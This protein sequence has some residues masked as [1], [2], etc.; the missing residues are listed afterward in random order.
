[1]ATSDLLSSAYFGNQASFVPTGFGDVYDDTFEATI[2]GRQ[3]TAYLLSVA[4]EGRAF[5]E[6]NDLIRQ[7]FGRDIVAEVRKEF[8]EAGAD[9]LIK[10]YQARTDKIIDEGRAQNLD[11]WAGIRKAEEIEAATIDAAQVAQIESERTAARAENNFARFGGAL[12]GGV[13]ASF[14]DP[15]NLATLPVGAGAGVGIL[16]AALLDGA[17]NATIETAEAPFNAQWQ[18]ELGFKYGLSEATADIATAGIGGAGLSALIRGGSKALG[19]LTGQSEKV[20]RDIALDPAHGSEVRGAASYMERVAQLDENIPTPRV[21]DEVSPFEIT[22]AHRANA[23]ETQDAFRNYREP[24]YN[25]NIPFDVT[26]LDV[27]RAAPPARSFEE[28]LPEKGKYTG[29]TQPNVQ[30]LRFME[31]VVAELEQA[32]K[33]S[34]LFTEQDGAGGA[35]QVTT[36]QLSTFPKWFRDMNAEG[37]NLSRDYVLKTFEKM[38]QGEALGKKEIR[39]AKALFEEARGL[40]EQNA[41]QI[42]N[43]RADRADRLARQETEAVDALAAR[44]AARELADPY[45]EPMPNAARQLAEDVKAGGEDAMMDSA[46]A[47]FD[48]LL[49]DEPDFTI[50]MED[51]SVKTMADLADEL[52]ADKDILQAVTVCGVG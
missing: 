2:R 42:L 35:P 43:F 28:G 3:P 41:Q 6:R 14:L 9:F 34:R 25:E 52:A 13:A 38:K 4:E 19:K 46:R 21:G 16:R 37:E 17:L 40:R 48:Q 29:Y 22:A 20:L 30:E 47:D 1:M 5:S 18:R 26:E 44:E 36:G 31:G 32:Q 49:A 51:G 7:R 50:V 24:A 11:A 27:T 12:A 8:P 23:Q 45:L 15:I 39:V 10:E 33:G